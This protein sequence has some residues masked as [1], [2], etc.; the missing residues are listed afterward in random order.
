MRFLY[1]EPAHD[2]TDQ[3]VEER[4]RLCAET[5]FTH[6]HINS[7]RFNQITTGIGQRADRQRAIRSRNRLT[8]PAPANLSGS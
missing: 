6:Q 7:R 2:W 5:L 3:T 8:G 1:L 4:L